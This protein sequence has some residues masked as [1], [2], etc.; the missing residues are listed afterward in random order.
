MRGFT[1]VALVSAASLALATGAAIPGG[2]QTT[3]VTTIKYAATSSSAGVTFAITPP[4]STTP[5][6]G[7][8]GAATTA[9]VSSSGPSAKGRADA[10]NV[11]NQSP[12]TAS[13]EAPPD[14]EKTVNSP[15]P[16]IAVPAV[17]SV[18]ALQGSA[19]STSEAADESPSTTNTG[20]FGALSI[21]VTGLPALPVIGTVGGSVN[22]AQ[23]KTQASA[24]AP[25]PTKV[26]GSA[27]SDGIVISADLD[28]SGLSAVCGLI[29][30]PQLQ[31]ACNSLA[32]P[33][34]L[35]NITTGTSDVEC[36]WDGHNAECDGGAATATVTLAGQAP[37]T[38]AP[39]QTVTIPDA[40]PFLVRVR[41]GDFE[42]SVEGDQG[43][44]ISA[45]ISV[46][47]IGQTR[48]NP[49]LITL[50]VGQSTAG[51]NGEITVDRQT[52][53]TGGGLLPFFLGGSALAVIG[54]GLRR[55]L[56]RA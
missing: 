9:E 28:I 46:E 12:V 3:T 36:S 23:M 27:S 35:I 41:A 19:K 43:S 38:V 5:A 7:I 15:V 39:G 34:Q 24:E 47:L 20:T 52:A 17:A 13:T 53:P 50:A 2:A 11:L 54:Y 21:N 33:S 18:G 26:S 4:G 44:A 42:E 45:G 14:D 31:Q 37:Q 55:Y 51:V 6:A 49:G 48:A 8:F 56:Q 32:T 40:D 30:I 29:P 1:R 22:V 10:L 25:K 16:A